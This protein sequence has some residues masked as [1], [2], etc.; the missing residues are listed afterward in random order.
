MF[1]LKMA[2]ESQNSIDWLKEIGK[3]VSLTMSI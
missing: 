2:D 1:L 3:I